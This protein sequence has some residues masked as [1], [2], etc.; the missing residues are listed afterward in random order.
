MYQ[1]E[2]V[3]MRAFGQAVKEAREKQGMSREK[4]AEILEL[5]PRYTMYVE[6]RGQHMSLQKLY[7]VATLFSI[8]VDQFFFP[9]TSE[10]KSTTRR[11]LDARLDGMDEKELLIMTG[12]A[13]AIDKNKET[14]E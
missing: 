6:T 12:T 3:N 8:S 1:K 5:S 10:S 7:E 13:E 11:Q 4:L 14:G 9:D 2:K